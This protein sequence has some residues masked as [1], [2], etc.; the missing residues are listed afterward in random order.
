[1]SLGF[2]SMAGHAENTSVVV[3]LSLEAFGLWLN[4][5]IV[6]IALTVR[7]PSAVFL[8]LAATLFAQADRPKAF[9]DEYNAW[10]KMHPLPHADASPER[11]RAFD[12]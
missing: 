10:F 9:Q 5:V 11:R 7:F 1:M 4:R 6:L 2:R 3:A 12:R 8:A